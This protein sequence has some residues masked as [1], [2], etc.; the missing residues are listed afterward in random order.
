MCQ[1]G[2]PTFV[3]VAKNGGFTKMTNFYFPRF[4]RRNV[5]L[6]KSTSLENANSEKRRHESKNSV[7]GSLSKMVKNDQKWPFLTF[8]P[9][10]SKNQSS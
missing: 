4:L 9:T 10:F 6:A 1:N 8:D 5:Y 3:K 7:R 2:D